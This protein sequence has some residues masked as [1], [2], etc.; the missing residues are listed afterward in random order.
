MS[1]YFFLLIVILLCTIVHSLYAK[2]LF[3]ILYVLWLFFGY[4][5]TK[6]KKW[7][8]NDITW[9]N[10]QPT[11]CDISSKISFFG[12]FFQKAIWIVFPKISWVGF[13]V[14][15]FLG[16]RIVWLTSRKEQELYLQQ[17]IL[18]KQLTRHPDDRI[19]MISLGGK[20]WLPYSY[21]MHLFA[22]GQLIKPLYATS[23]DKTPFV[24]C[25]KLGGESTSSSPIGEKIRSSM[26]LF[27]IILHDLFV[28]RNSD[29]ITRNSDTITQQQSR[30][31]MLFLRDFCAQLANQKTTTKSTKALF[32]SR[33]QGIPEWVLL[34]ITDSIPKDLYQS[35]LDSGLVYLVAASGGNIAFLTALLW[36]L[37]LAIPIKARK[38]AQV[39]GV[40]SYGVALRSNVA[41]QRAVLSSI[42]ASILSWKGRK[43][44]STNLL[45]IIV[46]F[47]SLYNPYLLVTSRWFILSVAG[48]R[49]IFHIPTNLQ[50]K[51]ILR[52]IA[53]GV[54]AFLAL[55]GPLL[56]L[57]QKVNFLTIVAS[58]PA[59]LITMVI[60]YL[61]LF[62]LLIGGNIYFISQLLYFC[63][64]WL[65]WLTQFVAT[66]GIYFTLEDQIFSYGIRLI[67]WV[68][69]RSLKKYTDMISIR[70]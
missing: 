60:T 65:S 52:N 64:K 9:H 7:P 30:Y 67:L 62:V 11:E 66:H 39:G 53:P 20:W 50:K 36:L 68:F 69:I 42:F 17:R 47:C 14:F 31:E 35:F 23:Y 61:S 22:K 21:D 25:S 13:V 6:C 18:Q 63:V 29:G 49:G 33:F 70:D 16:V 28:V 43:I 32:S 19:K 15:L 10:H 34:W 3:L 58:V 48:V 8:N 4:L 37:L 1:H 46:V 57:T 44:S 41:L 12:S 24:F 27:P 54:R 51:A 55:L 2:L 45:L 38:R 56:L 5:K 59:W 40:L 26:S